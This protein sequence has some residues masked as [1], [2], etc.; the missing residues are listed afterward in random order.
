MTGRFVEGNISHSNIMTNYRLRRFREM[1]E[2]IQY[3]INLDCPRLFL[4][5]FRFGEAL[6]I[7]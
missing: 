5:E 1:K 6:N 3:L 4:F 7:S 2:V